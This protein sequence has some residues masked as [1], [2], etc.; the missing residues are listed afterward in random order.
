VA[1]NNYIV[2]VLMGKELGQVLLN[3]SGIGHIV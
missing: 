1:E 2:V 3:G